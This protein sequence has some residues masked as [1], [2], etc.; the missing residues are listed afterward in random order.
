MHLHGWPALRARSLTIHLARKFRVACLS[1][2]L[3]DSDLRG[4]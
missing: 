4:M 3:A 1:Q 2:R